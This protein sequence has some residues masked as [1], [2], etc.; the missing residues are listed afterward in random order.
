M[1][2]NDDAKKMEVNSASPDAPKPAKDKKADE[3]TDL[4]SVVEILSSHCAVLRLR[5]IFVRCVLCCF[6]LC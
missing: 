4:V 2:A 6:V 3:K 5:C 1:S